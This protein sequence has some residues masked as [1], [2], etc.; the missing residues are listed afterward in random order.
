MSNVLKIQQ[1]E[2]KILTI[3]GKNVLL[4]SDVAVLYEVE[5]REINQ[6]VKNNPK[7]FPEGYIVQLDKDE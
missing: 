5:T 1:V 6:A 2:E 3:R 4:D 7:K